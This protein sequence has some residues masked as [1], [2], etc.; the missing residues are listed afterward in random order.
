[1][2]N[3]NTRANA[4]ADRLLLAANSLATFAEGLSDLEW[5]TPV[6]GDSDHWNINH[7]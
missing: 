6:L 5:K 4:L 2:S 1:M 3:L 7:L